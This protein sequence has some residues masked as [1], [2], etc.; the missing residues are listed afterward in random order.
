MALHIDIFTI[1][2]RMFSG[3]LEES[4]LARAIRAGRVDVNLLNLRDFTHDRHHSVDD[5]PYGGGP[6]MVFRPEPVFEVVESVLARPKAEAHETRK[7][8]LTPQGRRLLQQDLRELAAARW[9]LL[10][11]GHYE[12]F[13][14]RILQGLEFE[15]I[16]IGDYVLTGGE[17][18]AMVVLDGVA[19]LVPGV[20]GDSSSA[21]E[22]S[23]E[24]R[25]LD[26]PHYTRPPE[27]R[28]MA[29]P[30]ILRSG[31]HARIA[32]WRREEALKRTAERRAD[33]LANVSAESSAVGNEAGRE[34]SKN[35]RDK[36]SPQGVKRHG[37]NT[38]DG[39]AV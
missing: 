29:V 36:E 26:H 30:E 2:P 23:F 24:T 28:G 6:G 1:F 19:R 5:R 20:L 18:P 15:E 35:M 27:Y 14:E 22:E 37:R 10:L 32:K 17:I 39:R 7:I 16:S 3:V 4:I 8:V 31:N 12:G 33:L 13:D 34:R 11:C 25:L 21:Q 38:R 9:I